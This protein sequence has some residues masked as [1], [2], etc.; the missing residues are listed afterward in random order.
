[1]TLEAGLTA[2]GVGNDIDPEMGL[3]ARAMSGMAFVLVGF[4][5][6]IEARG[7]ES[8]GQLLDDLIADCHGVAHRR[9]R[10]SAT[11][12]CLR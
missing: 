9:R 10:H 3:S 7:L 1:V 2:E 12:A 4:I 11:D 6:D 5:H 8:L